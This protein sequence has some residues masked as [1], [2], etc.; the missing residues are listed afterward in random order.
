[1]AKKKFISRN[2]F[3]VYRDRKGRIR[4]FSPRLK[5]KA[6]VRSKKTKARIRWISKEPR[7]FTKKQVALYHKR[8]KTPIKTKAKKI[9]TQM[10]SIKMNRD[11]TSQIPSSFV[12]PINDSIKMDGYVVF[13]VHVV[14]PKQEFFTTTVYYDQTNIPSFWKDVVRSQIV[15]ELRKNKVRTSPKAISKRMGNTYW[16][17]G[18][19][20]Y[21]RAIRI[22]LFFR[23]I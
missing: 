7:Y 9:E 17:K 21:Y 16:K 3:I 2:E 22:G 23:Y 4:K 11:I 20:I 1:M 8:K 19:Y 5:L 18:N 13:G 15:Q 6:E 14:T 12:K 10:I